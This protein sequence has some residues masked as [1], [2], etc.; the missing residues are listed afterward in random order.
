MIFHVGRIE[1]DTEKVR[2]WINSSKGRT[3][4]F[5]LLI[6][7]VVLLPL[8]AWYAFGGRRG[9]SAAE[10]RNVVLYTTADE[11]VVRSLT[12]DFTARTGIRVGITREPAGRTDAL[13]QR[14]T[15]EKG[16]PRAD[17]WWGADTA[18]AAR[19]AGAGVLAPWTSKAESL[20]AGGWPA[21]LRDPGYRWYGF[22]LRA[23]VI[24]FNTSS[25][26]KNEAPTRLRDLAS[27]NWRGRVGLPDPRVPGPARAHL[28]FLIATHGEDAARSWLLGIKDNGAVVLPDDLAVAQAVGRGDVRLGLTSAD[29]VRSAQGE[30]WPVDFVP[31]SIDRPRDRVE[32][33]R[34]VGVVLTPDTVARV[35]GSPN[36]HAGARLADFLLSADAERILA[37]VPARR[38]PIIPSVAGEFAGAAFANPTPIDWN[39]VNAADEAAARIAREVLGP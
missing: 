4:T 28:A 29:A 18:A 13:V 30:P 23:R 34:S 10:Q 5:R 26:A 35:V 12:D 38:V 19:L 22:A 8:A 37:G 20:V 32:G 14:L 17:V 31:E 9:T 36:P 27:P 15:N 3:L 16:S 1:V 6:A 39:A 21:G 24:A 33:L 2:R 11:A 7:G 25:L